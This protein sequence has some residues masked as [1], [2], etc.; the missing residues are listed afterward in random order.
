MCDYKSMRFQ[1]LAI[2]SLFLLGCAENRE[3]DCYPQKIK[4]IAQIDECKVYEVNAP[5]RYEPG[6][7]V[8]GCYRRLFLMTKCP[9]TMVDWHCGKF[10]HTQNFTTQSN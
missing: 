3:S 4:E 7:A 1:I 9:G 6:G 2:L 5:Q 8:K 10:C